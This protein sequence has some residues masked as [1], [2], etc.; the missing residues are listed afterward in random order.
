VKSFQ[1][2]Y[3]DIYFKGKTNT[4]GI[5]VNEVAYNGNFKADLGIKIQREKTLNL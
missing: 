1:K 2:I 5:D 3:A 4:A